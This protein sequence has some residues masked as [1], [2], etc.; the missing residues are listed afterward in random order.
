[1]GIARKR[2]YTASR[3]RSQRST[4]SRRSAPWNGSTQPGYSGGSA[5]TASNCLTSSWVSVSSAAARLSWSWS[6]RFAPMMTEV[7]TGF[8]KS[9]AIESTCRTTAM[10]FRD[11]NH[12]VEDLPGP[13]FV[14]DRIVVVGAARICGLLVQPAVLAG[15]QAAGKRTPYEQADLFGLQ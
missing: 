7:T 13:L 6:R 4:G 15:Q 2:R 10:C 3:K 14:H 8:A 9:H 11:R 1:M 12:H 5:L